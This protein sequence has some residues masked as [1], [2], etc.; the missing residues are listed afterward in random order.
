[1][2]ESILRQDYKSFKQHIGEEINFDPIIMILDTFHENSILQTARLM[3]QEL[4]NLDFPKENA[5]IEFEPLLE[6]IQ[7]NSAKARLIKFMINTRKYEN[8]NGNNTTYKTHRVSSPVI[9]TDSSGSNYSTQELLQLT[10]IAK[11]LNIHVTT[12]TNLALKIIHHL[13]AKLNKN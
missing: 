11:E 12:N 9:V 7:E 5:L 6:I 4:I 10:Q 2:E 8:S 3:V 13:R 1:M